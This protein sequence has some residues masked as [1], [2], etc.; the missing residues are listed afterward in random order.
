MRG[1]PSRRRLRALAASL[2]PPHT[3]PTLSSSHQQAPAAAGASGIDGPLSAEDLRHWDEEG[4]VVLATGAAPEQLRAVRDEIWRL[5][6]RDEADPQTW[7]RKLPPNASRS[8]TR[9]PFGPATDSVDP[10]R[11]QADLEVHML[12]LWQTDAQWQIRQLPRIH[13]AFTQLWGTRELWVE[14][15]CVNL[16]PPCSDLH[17]GWGGHTYCHWDWDLAAEGLGIQGALYLADTGIN[18]GG[19]RCMPGFSARFNA[20]AVFREKTMAWRAAAGDNAPGGCKDLAEVTGLP[21]VTLPGRAGD[22]KQRC[23]LD[24]FVTLPVSLTLQAPLLQLVIWNSLLPHGNARNTA[25]T[26]RQAM[27]LTYKPVEQYTAADGGIERVREQRVEGWREGNAGEAARS[28]GA[29]WRPA[30]LTPL[31][32]RLLGSAEW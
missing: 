26:A 2:A 32:E 16:K 14:V 12:G 9:L 25:Q 8:G 27:F 11:G 29:P 28:G 7:Y 6:Q 18:G 4:Y 23:F 22:V 5:A 10:P 20:D 21:V 31:G 13:A 3:H 15:D 1:S 24:L 17:P 30:A 19:F